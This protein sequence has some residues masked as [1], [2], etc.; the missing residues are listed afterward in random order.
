MDAV[1]DVR[2]DHVVHR[3]EFRQGRQLLQLLGAQPLASVLFLQDS[4]KQDETKVLN[5]QFL[6]HVS[7]LTTVFVHLLM[8]VP[9]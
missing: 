6:V 8:L 9:R 5:S 7:V 2:H 1:N 4:A 3:C